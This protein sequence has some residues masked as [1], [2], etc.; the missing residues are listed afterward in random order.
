MPPANR[1][2]V[3][4]RRWMTGRMTAAR[5]ISPQ[6]WSSRSIDRSA[7]RWAVEASAAALIAPTLVP[8]RIEG[9][10]PRGLELRQQHRQDADLVGAPRPATG[11]H[12]ANTLPHAYII[13][14]RPAASFAGVPARLVDTL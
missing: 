12:Q 6:R 13:Y 1:S 8:T 7:G 2:A 3:S 11:Q 5:L 9:R 10:S 14:P 4:G